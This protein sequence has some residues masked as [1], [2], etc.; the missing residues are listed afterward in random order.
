MT[1]YATSGFYQRE[2]LSGK[3]AVIPSSMFPYYAR[4][5]SG[6]I[7]QYTFDNIG[8]TVPE[9]VKLCCCEL[10]EALYRLDSNQSVNGGISS[11]KVGDISVSYADAEELRGSLLD[12]VKDIIYAWL[13]DSGLLYRGG[14]YAGE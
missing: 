7:R 12:T 2:Y 3:E 6:Y 9:C 1:V 14:R 4:K 5:A 13:S 10:A 11:E 8:E